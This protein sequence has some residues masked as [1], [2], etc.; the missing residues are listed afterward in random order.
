MLLL[1]RCLPYWGNGLGMKRFLFILCLFAS[2]PSSGCEINIISQDFSNINLS[3]TSGLTKTVL[4]IKEICD[5]S[6]GYILT[7]S[8]L[9]EGKLV[10]SNGAY[11]YQISYNGEPPVSLAQNY[12]TIYTGVSTEDIKTLQLIFPSYP[13]AVA[14]SYSDTLFLSLSTP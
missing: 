9:N 1:R 6:A 11:S 4:S 8:S 13:Q 10:S 3:P 7:I 2:Y 14:G 12:V 5:D